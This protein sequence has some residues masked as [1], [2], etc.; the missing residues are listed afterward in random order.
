MKSKALNALWILIILAGLLLIFKSQIESYYIAKTSEA[1]TEISNEKIQENIKK[2][3]KLEGN[4]EYER[5]FDE[6]NDNEKYFKNTEDKE[7]FSKEQKESIL[8]D[9]ESNKEIKKSENLNNNELKENNNE[10]KENNNELKENNNELKENGNKSNITFDFNEV[11]NI[12]FND[13]VEANLN[14]EE[15]PIVGVIDI[16]SVN[17]KLPIMKG[18]G[19]SVLASGAGTMK[20]NQEMGK[21]NY[22]L[23]S[24]HIEGRNVL[25]GPLFQLEINDPIYLSDGKYMYLYETKNI[26]TIEVYD[27]YIIKDVK[28]EKLLTLITCAEE[29]TMRLSV[30]ASFVKKIKI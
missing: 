28:N 16:P 10:L 20:E 6:D 18:V 11:E 25:F 19:K 13:V 22:A 21:R 2:Y 3:E 1:L 9:E 27:V 17:L 30:Q 23:A 8:I 12:S 15:L 5:N 7:A 26:K 14:K 24:H 29:G 4:R